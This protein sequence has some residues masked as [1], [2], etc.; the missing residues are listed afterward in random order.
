MKKRTLWLIG[1]T[2]VALLLAG[3]I[4]LATVFAQDETP[5]TPTADA[6]PPFGGPGPGRMGMFGRGFF[7]R[8][9]WTIFDTVAETLGLTPTELFTRLHDGATLEE[10]AEEQGVAM[11]DIHSAVNA[12]RADAMRQSIEQAVEDGRI[13]QEQADWML[14]GLDKGY[15]PMG[16]GRGMGR[17]WGRG[18]NCPPL[19]GEE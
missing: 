3:T 12:A 15:L 16:M 10:I 4:G 13:T 18:W 2:V 6:L 17:G 7:G 11:D 5:P 8:S 1:A 14:E 9:G 19:T